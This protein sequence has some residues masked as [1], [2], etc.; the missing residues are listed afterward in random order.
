MTGKHAAYAHPPTWVS[1]MRFLDRVPATAV[2]LVQRLGLVLRSARRQVRRPEV[3]GTIL[4][5]VL[6]LLLLYLLVIT[7][8]SPYGL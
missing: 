2:A 4:L 3:L 8:F 1:R 5:I 7:P 6:G